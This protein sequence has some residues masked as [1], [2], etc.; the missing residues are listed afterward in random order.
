MIVPHV[1][2]YQGSKRKIADDI[3][4]YVDFEV[5]GRFYEPFAGSAAITLAAAAQNM[6]SGYVIG[7][8]YEPLMELWKLIVEE[9]EG[10]AS[11]YEELWNAQL[12][13]PREFFIKTREQ[14]NTDLDPVKFLYL[15]ARCVKNAIR[16]NSTGEFNQSADNR[17][18][19]TKPERVRREVKRAAKLLKEKI[20]IR[21]GDFIEILEDA[22]SNDVVYMDPPWQGTSNNRDPRYAHLLELD[23]LIYGLDSLN[24]RNVPFMLSF[25]GVCGDKK[26]GEDLPEELGLTKIGIHA[27]R[28]SQATLLGR[29]EITIEALYLSPALIERCNKG[30]LVSNGYNF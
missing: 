25:D 9:P 8:K 4:R 15:V 10:V 7:D 22:T 17:R 29:K 24:K 19:G 21:A 28:S 5:S 23:R 11:R 13:G 20:E 12:S 18:L 27:G 6:A 26:Y 1:I 30:L 2:P 3:L 14:F 16:F